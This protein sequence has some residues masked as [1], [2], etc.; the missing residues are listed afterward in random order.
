LSDRI[1]AMVLPTS[2]LSPVSHLSSQDEPCFVGSC[3]REK[4]TVTF[5]KC[6]VRVNGLMCQMH[7]DMMLQLAFVIHNLHG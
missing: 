4:S 7:Y 5:S 2:L 1:R 6:R 3:S